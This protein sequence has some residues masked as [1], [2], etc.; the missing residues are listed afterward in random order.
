MTSA[1]IPGNPAQQFLHHAASTYLAG[2]KDAT[3]KSYTARLDKFM[4]WYAVQSPAPFLE[5]LRGYI[6]YLQGEGLKPRSIQAHIN[7][8]KGLLKTAAALDETDRL[9]A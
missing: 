7:T 1:I 3:I 5:H 8:I 4:A 2:R 6:G 9:A